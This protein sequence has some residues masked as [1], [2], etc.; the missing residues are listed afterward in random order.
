MLSI[1]SATGEGEITEH[2]LTPPRSAMLQ[3]LLS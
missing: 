3:I 2:V 1:A